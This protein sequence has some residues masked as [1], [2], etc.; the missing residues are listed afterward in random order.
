MIQTP[1]TLNPKPWPYVTPKP[2]VPKALCGLSNI[3]DA[4]GHAMD[5]CLPQLG[6]DMDSEFGA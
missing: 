1:Y 3:S 4:V 6:G 5:G 2:G